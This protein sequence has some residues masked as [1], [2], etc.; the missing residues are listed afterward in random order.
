MLRKKKNGSRG[1]ISGAAQSRISVNILHRILNEMHSYL[2]V[3][4]LETDELLFVND[5]LL[6]DYGIE[7]D[8]IGLPCWK[9]VRTGLEKRCEFC[10]VRQLKIEPDA[11]IEWEEHCPLTGRYYRNTDRLIEWSGGKKAHLH[12]RIDISD[13]RTNAEE[14]RK[15]LDQQELMAAMSRSFITSADLPTLIHDALRMSGEFLDVSKML[16]AKYNK[17]TSTLD[18]E[19]V[20]Y[21]PHQEIFRPG[22]TALPF[23]PGAIEYEAYIVDKVSWVA[24]EDITSME[25][26]SYAA[27]HGIK[28]LIG[29]PIFVFGSFW[30]LLSVNECVRT[31][32]WTESDVH[33]VGLIGTV[34]SGVVERHITEQNLA[35]MSSI[36]NSSPQFIAYISPD[37]GFE[38][39]NQGALDLLGYSEAEILGGDIS[40]IFGSEVCGFIK[41]ELYPRV[42]AEGKSEFEAPARRKD[43]QER[44]LSFSAFITD[45]KALG[46]G[47]IALDITEKRLLERELVAAKEHAVQ[48]SLAKGEFLSRMSHEMRTPLNAIIGMT[49]IAKASS[50]PEKREYCLKKIDSAS[51]HLLGVINDILDMSKIEANK[52]ELSD[53]EF[54]LEAMLMRVVNVVNFRVEEKNQNFIINIAPDTPLSLVSDEQRLAQ[55]IANLLSNAVKFTPENG[56]IRLSVRREMEDNGLLIVRFDVSDTGIGISPEQQ[57]RLFSSF[58][59]ADGG[60]SRRFGGT[61]LGLAISKRI[62][63]M[64][65]GSIWINSEINKGAT[66]SFTMRAKR[67]ATPQKSP[68]E[69]KAGLAGN[70]V[71]VVDDAPEIREFF[72]EL[73]SALGMQCD[74]VATEKEALELLVRRKAAPYNIVFVDWNMPDVNVPEFARAVKSDCDAKFVIAMS[75]A[76]EWSAIDQEAAEGGVDT[77]LPKP[78]FASHIVRCIQECQ[79]HAP[80]AVPEM[81]LLQPEPLEPGCFSGRRLLLAEDIEVNREIV[82]ALLADTGITIDCAENGREAMEMFSLKP[83]IYDMIFMDIHMPE[84]DGYEATRHIRTL[85]APASRTVPIIA[86]TANVFRED[87]E[88]CLN[89]GMDDHIGKPMDT[90]ELFR[91]LQQYMGAGAD[92]MKSGAQA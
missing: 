76:T 81:T 19:Y 64:M 40:R 24:Y 60:I 68:F 16:I 31:R 47:I 28:A 21:N 90:R 65:G 5:T 67:G 27:S 43:G 74:A 78:L 44:I 38:Y 75:S 1:S 6:K 61:G 17:E 92:G 45:F 69:A 9:I 83:D 42:L 66:F 7:E 46:M 34:I 23:M 63:E 50:D 57:Q 35:R 86:M 25:E 39:F 84:V 85:P 22:K 29:V 89:A 11:V 91:L 36:V 48:T 56:T 59:Q 20:W 15:R 82:L 58:E 30:G 53:A 18:E 13:I 33:L 87:I 70:K 3:A 71:L 12:H 49:G 10:P 88:K 14:L 62:V 8:P 73:G 52:F 4:D 80:D 2:Y 32:P 77:F 72:L 26:F 79:G 54:N 55:V 51:T 37:G 41:Q